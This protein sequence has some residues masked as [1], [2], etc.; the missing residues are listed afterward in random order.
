MSTEFGWISL[1]RVP[2]VSTTFSNLIKI[3]NSC[4][5]CLDDGILSFD[6]TKDEWS[7]LDTKHVRLPAAAWY[8]ASAYNPNTK[9]IYILESK[10]MKIYDMETMQLSGYPCNEQGSLIYANSI[11]HHIGGP[12]SNIHQIWNDESKQFQQVHEFKEYATGITSFGLIYDKKRKD[13]LLFGG[14]DWFVPQTLNDIHRYSMITSTWTKL[15]VKLPY[16]LKHFGCVITKDQEYIIILGGYYAKGGGGISANDQI[17]VLSMNCMK[18]RESQIR[19]PFEGSCKA[20]IME[21]KQENEL[22][23]HGFVKKEMKKYDI[24]IPF[25]LISFIVIWHSIEYVHVINIDGYHWKINID[26]IF[27]DKQVI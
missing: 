4:F 10:L 2:S 14:C 11:C 5:I 3:D 22:L 20:F 13:L 1:R 9:Q 6:V 24:N 7:K 26:K 12:R 21:N 15:R 27:D 17:F 25:A 19:L 23:V 16:K 8:D 18:F